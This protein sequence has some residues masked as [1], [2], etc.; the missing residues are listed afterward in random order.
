MTR[1][2]LVVALALV[3]VGCGG[4]DGGGEDGSSFVPTEIADDCL[5]LLHG[6]GSDGAPPRVDG[7]RLVIS[8][9]GN[10][11][12]WDAYQWEYRTADDYADAR[13]VVLNVLNQAQCLRVVIHGFS[14]GAAM[15]AALACDAEFHGGPVVGYVVDD[16]VT[17]DVPIGCT[18]DPDAEVAL[19][20]TGALPDTAGPGTSCASVDWTCL[21]DT[22]RSIDD[23]AADLGV[24]WQASIHDDHRRYDDPPELDRWFG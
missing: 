12:G 21:G 6:K 1:L 22:V 15:T 20:W 16:P 11:N 3:A 23:Y 4:S 19:Y 8:P 7:D 14:N 5:L 9:R 24:D 13:A 18:P 17:D 10:A 2:L